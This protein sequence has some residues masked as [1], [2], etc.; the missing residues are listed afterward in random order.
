MGGIAAALVDEAPTPANLRLISAFFD[1][2][3]YKALRTRGA[4]TKR[5][6]ETVAEVTLG[7]LAQHSAARSGGES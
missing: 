2:P 1:L 3:T 6:A 7:L 5:A 4:S